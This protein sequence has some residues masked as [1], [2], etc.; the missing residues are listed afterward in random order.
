M[1]PGTA[2]DIPKILFSGRKQQ[3]AQTEPPFGTREGPERSRRAISNHI[4]CANSNLHLLQTAV[5]WT[6]ASVF[7]LYA[8]NLTNLRILFQRAA[9]WESRHTLSLQKPILSRDRALESRW[10]FFWE[11]GSQ[12]RLCDS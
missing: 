3:I 1:P 4:L 8:T 6:K 2:I 10:A 9:S 5:G 7:V 12:A 11:K